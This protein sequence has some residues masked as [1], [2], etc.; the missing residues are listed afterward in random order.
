MEKKDENTESDEKPSQPK[1]DE[2]QLATL[3]S[4]KVLFFIIEKLRQGPIERGAMHKLIKGKFRK[5]DKKPR[6][7]FE[8]LV[9]HD[10]IREYEYLQ[11]K[12]DS[13][14]NEKLFP[15]M[16]VDEKKS[17]YILVKDFYAIRRPPM[18]ILDI[19]EE[20]ELS[21][22]EIKNFRK[23]IEKY[24]KTY[25]NQKV[26]G[27]D[28]DVINVFMD[29]KMFAA[30]SY[31]TN[32]IYKL[33]DISEELKSKWKGEPSQIFDKLEKM[34]F[35]K[36]FEVKDKNEKWVILKTGIELQPI[37]PQYLI[38]NIN[39]IM[40][41]KKLNKDFAL[42]TLNH[43]KKYFLELEEPE[44]LK[45]IVSKIDETKDKLKPMLEQLK[46]SIA[47]KELKGFT[48][49]INKSYATL[50]DLNKKIGD[51]FQVERISK[52]W[53]EVQEKLIKM[54]KK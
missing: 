46:K 19:L 6:D 15:Y 26:S 40:V 42:L 38:R 52:D 32:K 7:Y 8:L 50:V 21:L 4:D 25:T 11:Q 48:K 12:T 2:F 9:S 31:L 5:L 44:M 35:V 34:D 41:D 27:D 53:K 30:I 51:I 45:K 20:S 13:K 24:F 3:I 49:K 23:E 39:Q 18:E 28:M 47:E 16:K 43:L 22:K 1:M 17:F 10:F 14:D 29:Q 37:F 33:K 36:I 54:E